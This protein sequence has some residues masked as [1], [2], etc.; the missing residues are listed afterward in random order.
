MMCLLFAIEEEEDRDVERRGNP[1]LS[2]K[3]VRWMLFV[4]AVA[5]AG[6]LAYVKLVWE[7]ARWPLHIKGD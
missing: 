5:V 1:Y 4:F 6:A 7:P 3:G 2:R